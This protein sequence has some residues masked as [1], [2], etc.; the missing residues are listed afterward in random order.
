[1]DNTDILYL[2]ALIIFIGGMY[3][4]KKLW[5]DIHN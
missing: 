3:I 4:W 2:I 1:M 5:D